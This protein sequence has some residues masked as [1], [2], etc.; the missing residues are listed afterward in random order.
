MCEP[1]KR[2]CVCIFAFVAPVLV[3]YPETASRLNYW[4]KS[5]SDNLTAL[6]ELPCDYFANKLSYFKSTSGMH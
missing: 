6:T 4:Q 1:T 2:V 5:N 3:S